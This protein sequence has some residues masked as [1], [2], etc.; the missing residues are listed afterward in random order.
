MAF[1]SIFRRKAVLMHP[2]VFIIESLREQDHLESRLEGNLIAQLLKMGG[3][4]PIYRRV[5]SYQQFIDAISEFETSQYRYLHLSCHGN[6]SCLEFHFGI[7][8]FEQF[9]ELIHDKLANRRM[10]V[11]AC[12]AVNSRLADLLI[13]SSKCYSIIGPYEPIRF[14]DAAIIWNSYY[15]LAFKNEQKIMN[16]GLILKTL[17]ALTKLYQINLNY[18]SIS[19]SKGN[20]LRQFVGINRDS[21]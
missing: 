21:D 15:Y 5:E 16:R 12:N 11:S 8:T 17:R 4:S 3:R 18:Y 1:L 9:V 13:P 20:K 19:Q 7:M 2:E 10:F 14:D 6:E